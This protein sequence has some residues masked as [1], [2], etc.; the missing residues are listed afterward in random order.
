MKKKKLIF[1][2]LCFFLIPCIFLLLQKE[3]REDEDVYYKFSDKK[4]YVEY[5]SN[6]LDSVENSNICII[7]K[8]EKENHGKKVSDFVS[9]V[10]NQYIEEIDLTKIAELSDENLQ[11]EM[12]KWARFCDVIN[13]S[14]DLP[15]NS[16][17]EHIKLVKDTF[18]PL[19]TNIKDNNTLIVISAGN[20]KISLDEFPH[21]FSDLAEESNASNNIIVVSQGTAKNNKI[22]SANV[23]MNTGE[24]V[25]FVVLNDK[26]V[27]HG[28]K[29]RGSSFA[30]PIVTGLVG[31]LLAYGIEPTEITSVLDTGNN[32]KDEGITY[33]AIMIKSI[34][35]S[36]Q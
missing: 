24:A 16:P 20:D 25:D 31:N 27:L 11:I 23:T 12:S 3:M 13:I 32:F 1:G 15:R 5:I 2:L 33:K 6:P 17:T 21:I 28:K 30:A 19:F 14:M 22:S 36:A 35:E 7:D 8:F 9:I 10:S 34:Y 26:M 4:N 18:T 29:E